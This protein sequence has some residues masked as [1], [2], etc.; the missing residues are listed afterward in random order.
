MPLSAA[1]GEDNLDCQINE[2]PETL[3]HWEDMKTLV[4]WY[5]NPS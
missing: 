4:P 2:I 3:K 1:L 5:Q